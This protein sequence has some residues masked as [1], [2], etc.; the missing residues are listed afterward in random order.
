MGAWTIPIIV[1]AGAVAILVFV[2]FLARVVSILLRLAILLAAAFS[3]VAGTAL[4]MNNETVNLPPGVAVRSVR[5]LTVNHAATSL[6]GLGNARCA[7]VAHPAEGSKAPGEIHPG[8]RRRGRRQRGRVAAAPARTADTPPSGSPE[9][10]VYPELVTRGYPGIPR[11]RLFR[12]AE[13]AVNSLGGWKIIGSDPGAGTLDC[14]YT[15]RAFGFPD[16]VKIMITGGSEIELCSQSRTGEPGSTSWLRFFH[17]DFG[18][19][20]GH[21]QEF[22]SALEPRVEAFYRG[23]DERE[24]ARPAAR[25]SGF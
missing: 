9:E 16:D 12:L 5:F 15:T 13:D 8:R 18:A 25:D 2:P 17:G 21:I 4:L 7:A 14:V 20:M 6:K 11:D 23:H 19:N 24:K 3:G 1:A 10:D 22:Y